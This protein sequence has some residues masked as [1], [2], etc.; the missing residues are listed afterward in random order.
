MGSTGRVMS[1]GAARDVAGLTF[2]AALQQLEAIVRKLE[3]GEASLEDS[4]RLYEEGVTLQR[5]CE[6]K[7]ADAE[8]RIEEIRGGTDGQTPTTV[9]FPS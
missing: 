6:M 5:H 8:A 3:T 2:E 7:L 1:D 9:P 4:I